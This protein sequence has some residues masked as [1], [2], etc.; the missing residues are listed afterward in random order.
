MRNRLYSLLIS[1]LNRADEVDRVSC[2]T[3]YRRHTAVEG[4]RHQQKAGLLRLARYA[5][6]H[7]TFE[8]GGV[9]EA[10]R[11]DYQLPALTRLICAARK[12]QRRRGRFNTHPR[13][14]LALVPVPLRKLCH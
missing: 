1:K 13:A 6:I 2:G 3:T 4:P 7:P 14:W 11:A 12:N 10:T 9:E 8:K 5:A